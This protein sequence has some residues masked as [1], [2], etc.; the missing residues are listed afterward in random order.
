MKAPL[1]TRNE[2]LWRAIL[3]KSE[4]GIGIGEG[5]FSETHSE[6]ELR[7]LIIGGTLL[8][9]DHPIRWADRLALLFATIN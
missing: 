9:K 8:T 1:S 2:S 4:R 5:S 3:E 7:N 6:R